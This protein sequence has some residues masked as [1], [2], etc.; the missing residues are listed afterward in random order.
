VIA[1]V[2]VRRIGPGDVVLLHDTIFDRG[3]PRNGPEPDRTSWVDR[4]AMFAALELVLTQ[5]EDR[6]RFVTVPE[7]VQCGAPCYSYWFKQTAHPRG[8]GTLET[9]LGKLG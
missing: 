2:L 1:E 9:L 3:A 5:M 8:L 6:F 4:Q 7:L